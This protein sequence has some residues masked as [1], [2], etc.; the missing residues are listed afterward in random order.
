MK[1]RDK[2]RPERVI[3]VRKRAGGNKH[4]N[5]ICGRNNHKVHEGTLEKFYEVTK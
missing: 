1:F 3:V 5:C 2:A 4:W